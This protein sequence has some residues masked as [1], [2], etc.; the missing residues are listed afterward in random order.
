MHHLDTTDIQLLKLLQENS[1]VTTKELAKQVNLSATPVFE[2][3]KK[4]ENEGYIKKYVAVLDGDKLNKSLIAFCSIRLKEHTKI[5]GNKF[6]HDIKSLKEVTECYNTSGDF[7]FLL[8]V[9]VEDMKH[10]QDFVLNSLGSIENIGSAHTTFVMG[11]I[12]H[13]YDIPID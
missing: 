1:N 12:K 3:I 2:R 6:V 9:I 5:I 7:D 11:E 10:Y 13:S 4:L 8:K